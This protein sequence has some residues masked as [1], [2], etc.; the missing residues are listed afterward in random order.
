MHQEI[1]LKLFIPTQV[2]H[3]LIE[4]F[5]DWPNS[6]TEP[7]QYLTNYY[8]DTP[9]LS[10]AKLDCGFRVRAWNNQF[11][12][13][14]K[15][16]GN[17][18][19]GLH[20][21]PEFN[22]AI[23]DNHPNLLLFPHNIWPSDCDVSQLNRNLLC[24]FETNFKRSTWRVTFNNSIIEVA[25][26]Y[27]EVIAHEQH[28]P[29]CELELELVSG[30][31]ADIIELACKIS[32]HCPIKLG[33]HS[34]AV[35]GY[36]LSQKVPIK[37][38]LSQAMNLNNLM[39]QPCASH[40]AQILRYWQHIELDLLQIHQL[41]ANATQSQQSQLANELGLRWQWLLKCLNEIQQHLS[42]VKSC[43][44]VVSKGLLLSEQL[45][46]YLS[47]DITA[48]TA[49]NI[50]AHYQQLWQQPYYGKLQL[51]LLSLSH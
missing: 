11:E 38:Y 49:D 13:T 1:E 18:S 4:L 43:S 50:Q 16:A 51:Q 14:I 44:T 48:L 42:S 9:S 22:V 29:I 40:Y 47:Q 35:R 30:Q 32:Q 10:L 21:R 20:T 34:K 36:L 31:V 25:L 3:L 46:S 8:Y 41:L 15:T 5:N 12:Q 26:D 19:G 27:G 23:K 28:E 6:I 45:K 2:K 17:V 7:Q 39:A 37:R 33:L 24:L